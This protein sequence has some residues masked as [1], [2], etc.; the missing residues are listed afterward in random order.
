MCQV[1][2]GLRAVRADPEF[3]ALEREL[4]RLRETLSSVRSVTV[5]VNLGPD[6]APESATILEL[7]TEPIEGRRSLLW[8]LA[9]ANGADR[10][11]TPLQRG[12]AGPLG[13]PNEL[14]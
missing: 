9:G 7:S 4:P 12:E 10:G 14:V 1:A 8:R 2:D 13:R 3:A 11:L 6:L 5:G